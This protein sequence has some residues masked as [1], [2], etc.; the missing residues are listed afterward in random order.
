[1]NWFKIIGGGL[2]LGCGLLLGRYRNRVAVGRLEEVESWIRLLRFIR[3]QVECFSLPLS[4][5]LSRAD[6]DL[7]RRCGYAAGERPRE[8]SRPL[9]EC[10]FLDEECRALCRSFF[11]EFGRSYREEQ[12]CRCDYYI[13]LLE[14]RRALLCGGLP[15]KKKINATLCLSGAAALVILLA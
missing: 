6:P 13:R 1:M 11:D 3:L 7:L 2:I 5:I 10:R 9:A 15:G 8:S 14:E 12:L 4:A